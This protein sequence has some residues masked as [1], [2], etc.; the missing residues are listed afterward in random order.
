MN[1]IDT[2][3]KKI[4]QEKRLGL[5]THVVI[6]YPTLEKTRELVLMM[7]KEGVDFI[8]LQI[9][10][11]DPMGDGPTIRN[12]NTSALKNG[13]R[14]KD[15]FILA[16]KLTREDNIKIPLLFMTYYN[17]V[18]NYGV[19]KFCQD[20]KQVGIS[21]LIVP[22]YNLQHEEYEKFDYHANLN[23]LALIKFISLDSNQERM[24]AISKNAQGF[25]YCFSTRGVTGTQKN[26]DNY[27]EEHLKKAKN[28]FK[29]PIAVGFGISCANHIKFFRGQANIVIVGSALLKAYEQNGLNGVKIKIKELI[30]ALH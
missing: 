17:I 14:V 1:I 9:P 22:D 10:F 20:A 28:I 23:G 2:Q 4:Q 13:I 15:A 16:K 11:S 25:I 27:L 26:I 12:A 6:G 19:E 21:A 30:E 7:V 5:M 8:E 3:Y 18:F 24:K 29:K